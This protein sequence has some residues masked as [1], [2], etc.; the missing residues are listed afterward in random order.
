MPFFCFF[1]FSFELRKEVF[2]ATI[3][4]FVRVV[5][6]KVQDIT[7]YYEIRRSTPPV[8]FLGL[9]KGGGFPSSARGSGALGEEV[10]P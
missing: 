1:F 4:C 8:L 7:A 5:P 6:S 10:R 9:Q 3:F 2:H